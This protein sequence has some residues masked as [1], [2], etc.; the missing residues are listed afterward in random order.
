MVLKKLKEHFKNSLVIQDDIKDL[1]QKIDKYSK[2][3]EEISKDLSDKLSDIEKRLEYLKND[4]DFYGNI[5][6]NLNLNFQ[7]CNL[8]YLNYKVDKNKQNILLCGFYG[9]DNIGDEL[10]LQTV[11]EQFQ[12]YPNV[13]VTVLLD[14]NDKYNI[15]K[16]EFSNVAYLHYP[17]SVYDFDNLVSQFDKLIFGGGA[18]ID[19]VIYDFDNPFTITLSKI[20][21]DLSLKF[22]DSK[23]DV[24]WL[25]L[26][27]NKII[28]NDIFISKLIKIVENAKYISLRDTF[29]FDL[30]ASIGCNQSK[31]HIINDLVLANEKLNYI[32]KNSYKKLSLGFIP[33]CSEETKDQNINLIKTFIEILDKKNKSFCLKLIPFYGFVNNDI[34]YLNNLKNIIND[35]RVMV[36]PF[37]TNFDEILS[38]I[39]ENEY[40]VSMRYH[41]SLLA[42]VE[43]KKLLTI[44]YDLHQHYYNKINYLYERYVKDGNLI[45]LNDIENYDKLSEIFTN[46]IYKE[47]KNIFDKKILLK[48]QQELTQLVKNIVNE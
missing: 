8:E 24:Y 28:Q 21:I 4:L 22:I 44:L 43:N 19:D 31:M 30:L 15:L 2:V 25:S 41:C 7:Y 45:S 10:M 39:N 32:K 17:K 5:V 16:N 20:L 1:S 33:I 26:S 3:E 38:L 34:N 46:F 23:K 18:L 12:K 13:K 11:L 47:N 27:S 29:S 14:F 48:S 40:I 35:K 6:K 37:T 42:M 36:A 9:G